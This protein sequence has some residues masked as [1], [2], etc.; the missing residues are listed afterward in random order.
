MLRQHL[1]DSARG[2]IVTLLQHGG[3][4]VDEI[5]SKLGLTPNG[6]RVH[7]TAMERDGVVRRAGSRRGTTRPSSVFELTAETQQMLSGAYV[8]FLVQVVQLFESEWPE[9]EVNRFM[10][11]AGKRLAAEVRPPGRPTDSLR[12][13]VKAASELLNEQLGAVTHVEDNGHLVIRSAS[14]PLAALTGTY[15]SVCLAMES[16]VAELIGNAVVHECCERGERPRCCFDVSARP[17]R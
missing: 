3:L 15:R 11:K 1:L 17:S 5:A 10:R 4:T 13:R 8:P 14:C 7:L 6:V 12:A 9:A 2:R 16:F